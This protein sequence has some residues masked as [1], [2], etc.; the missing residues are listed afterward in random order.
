[1]NGWNGHAPHL[2]DAE[3][4]ERLRKRVRDLERCSKGDL[5]RD[6]EADEIYNLYRLGKPPQRPQYWRIT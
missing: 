5:E 1:M 6:A 3:E 2:A 4:L